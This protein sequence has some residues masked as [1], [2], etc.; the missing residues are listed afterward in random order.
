MN[1]KCLLKRHFEGYAVRTDEERV[2]RLG[3][4]S[5]PHKSRGFCGDPDL[6]D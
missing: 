4:A 1:E 3:L 5:P 2:T 6:H